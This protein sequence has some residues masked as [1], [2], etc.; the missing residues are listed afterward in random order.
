MGMDYWVGV[1]HDRTAMYVTLEPGASFPPRKFGGDAGFD[2]ICLIP[3][4][5][6]G[7]RG[8]IVIDP[9]E[10]VDIP[11]G[12]RVALPDGYWAEIRGRSSTIWK[13]RLAVHPGVIDGG[14]RGEL[15]VLV[16]NQN[17]GSVVIENGER[18]AQ[19]ILHRRTTPPVIEVVILPPSEDG[20]GE[21][22]FG[23]TGR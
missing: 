6:P 9:H 11:T 4:I 5:S 18:L 19:L 20:R 21:Q 23:S 14:Y 15:R 10:F 17:S 22:G 3:P 12:V 16:Q 13:K 8:G 2:L 1:E 7:F